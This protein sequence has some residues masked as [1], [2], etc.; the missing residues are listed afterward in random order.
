MAIRERTL[1]KD[2]PDYAISLNNLAMLLNATDRAIEAQPLAE[3]AVAIL[4]Q[5]LGSEHP[6]TRIVTQNLATIRAAA[7]EHAGR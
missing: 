6:N 2:H 5:A 1:G 4:T 7:G 3:Q